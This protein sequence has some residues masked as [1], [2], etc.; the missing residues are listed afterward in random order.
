VI[1]K[2]RLTRVVEPL[3]EEEEEE[4]EIS[5]FIRPNIG[6]IYVESFRTA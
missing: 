5:K 4:E 3:E 6:Q 1:A 2:P